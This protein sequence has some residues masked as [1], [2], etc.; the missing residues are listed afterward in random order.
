[1]REVSIIILT[2]NSA[3]FIENL[4]KSLKDFKK[5]SE[6]VL[7][8]NNSSDNTVEIAKN[9]GDVR[10]FKT[11]K[12]L[13]FSRGINFGAE[14][15]NGEYLL[16]INPDAVYENGELIDL[17][18]I[19]KKENVGIVG[20]KLLDYDGNV[21]KSAGKFFNLFETLLIVFGLDENLGVR[22]SPKTLTKVDFVSGGLMMV[23]SDLFKKLG[24][25][26]EKFFMYVED[27][28]FCFRAKKEG[29][30]TVF[31][32][33]VI[34]SHKGQGSSDKTFAVVNIY[35]GILY[36]FKKHKNYLEYIS[37]KAVLCVKA[38]FVY[39]LGIITNNSYYKNTYRQAILAIK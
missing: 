39:S 34:F 37:I 25:F 26:D 16:F 10:V 11:E 6:V 21:E 38:I 30:E 5:D 29:Y 4:L 28:E 20:G 2:Y 7:V 12:N 27:M 14:K 22:F 15:A 31:F 23:S 24:G 33:N 36:F 3:G 9:F 8:D 35:K 32:P 13:G 19:L 18:K 1:M 17:I